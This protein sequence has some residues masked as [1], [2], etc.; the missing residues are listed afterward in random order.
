MALARDIQ[1]LQTGTS[2]IV[3]V[4]TRSLLLPLKSTI[5][6]TLRLLFELLK[7]LLLLLPLPP[8]NKLRNSETISKR[9]HGTKRV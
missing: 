5:R 9:I 7:L 8:L 2:S 1:Y 6:T 3:L 4:A